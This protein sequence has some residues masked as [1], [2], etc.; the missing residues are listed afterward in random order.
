MAALSTVDP[1][2]RPRTP[3]DQADPAFATTLAHGLD[4][5][6]AFRNRSGSLSNADLA[7]HT[8]LSRPTVSR[9]TYTLAQLGYLKRD[10]KG[11]FQ[12]GLGILAAAYPVLS[13]LKIRQLAR[14]LMRDFA[15]YT[16]GTVSI[17]MPFGLDFIYVETLRTT[18]AVTHLPDV[19]FA[20]S[21]APTAVGRALLSLFTTD[22]LDA[23]VANVKA[24]RPKK[25]TMCRRGRC[26]MSSF[27]RSAAL[28]SRS[29]NGGARFLAS[30]R[31]YT[32]HRRVI[33]FPS[34][35]EFPRF[36]ST[37]NRSS[38]NAGR[39]CW[40]WRA[41]SARWPPTTEYPR[42]RGK[43]IART[44]RQIWG[45]K[46]EPDQN[47]AGLRHGSCL[48]RSHVARQRRAGTE[49]LSEPSDPHRRALPRRRHRR[50]RRPR[51]DRTGRPRLETDGRRR[52]KAG[53]QQQY[54]HGFSGAQRTRRLHLVGHRPGGIGQPDA[55]QGRRL[56]RA[57]GPQMRRP[58][59]LESKR[60]AGA[61][62]DA[63]Q[64]HQGIRRNRAQEA[65]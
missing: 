50:H 7:L 64:H 20:S 25:P 61:S 46:D 47:R 15:A 3:E 59:G 14:P 2:S 12:L 9:L 4:V 55:L 34:I 42:Q 60:G 22:E 37:P 40:A 24:E 29:A 51:R 38:A 36:V 5:L 11:R 33:V 17:A 18:D 45:G 27:A 30:P 26:P 1:S 13:A 19:G 54:R 52:S 10:A 31:R 39:A 32:A 28:R 48:D 16:G 6:A 63:G 41:A 44:M 35:A 49:Q 58:R 56:G 23:Y 65:G 43:R 8:G 53:W 21:L 62:I 57:E